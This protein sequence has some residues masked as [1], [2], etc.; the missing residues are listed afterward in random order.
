VR[1]RGL[2]GANFTI[3]AISAAVVFAAV[4]SAAV[5]YFIDSSVSYA[6]QAPASAAVAPQP[7]S[8][9]GTLVAVSADSVTARGADGR[10]RTYMITADTAAITG[11]GSQVGTAGSAFAVNDEVSI[12]GVMLDGTPVATA[13]AARSVSSLDGPPMDYAL[14]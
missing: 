6:G 9:E 13:V 8:Q 4:V 3:A 1:E 14:P 7:I 2:N 10:D 12:V 11:T 5:V